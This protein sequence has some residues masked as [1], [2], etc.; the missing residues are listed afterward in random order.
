MAPFFRKT[1]AETAP[2]LNLDDVIIAVLGVLISLVAWGAWETIAASR[3][4]YRK[5]RAGAAD[6]FVAE[7]R[8]AGDL[9]SVALA[10]DLA[11]T[12]GGPGATTSP[13]CAPS[14]TSDRGNAPGPASWSNATLAGGLAAGAGALDWLTVDETVLDAVEHLTHADIDH[15]LDLWTTFSD[16]DYQLATPGFEAMLRG[17]V[18]EQE[19]FAQLYQWAADDLTV[20]EAS[21]HA[22][23]DLT[24]GG[25]EFNV[26]VGADA[27]TIAD[28]L[29]NHP[30]IP[31]IVNDDMQGLPDDALHVDLTAPIDPDILTG[32]SVI[33]A[34][35]LSLSDLQDSMA[36]ALGPALASYDAGDLLDSAGDLAVPL[37]GTAVRV[38]RAGVR[39]QRLTAHHGDT[40]RAVRNVATDVTLVTGGLTAG[41][42]AGVG[43]GALI[44]IASFGA[45]AGLGT[46]VIGPAIGSFLGA[47][48]GGKAAAEQRMRPLNDAR[49]SASSAVTDYDAT[50]SQALTAATTAWNSRVNAAEQEL[51]ATAT[52]L[53][54][55]V[56]ATLAHARDDLASCISDLEA[57][58]TE[59]LAA[60][61]GDQLPALPAV[62]TWWRR[63]QWRTAADEA[64]TAP[65]LTRLDVLCA[66]D[67]GRHTAREL[68]IATSTRRARVLAAAAET[69][70]RTHQVTRTVKA[71]TLAR[72]ADERAR[73]NL[74]VQQQAHPAA[75]AVWESGQRV[76]HELVATGAQ[77]PKWVGENLP[78]IPR[79]ASPARH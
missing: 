2:L 66:T 24:L 54:Q 70:R 49:A 38:V 75:M 55:R 14:H 42:A 64:L 19:V 65:L 34:D 7:L 1:G 48:M 39:E 4:P 47:R 59:A 25:Q 29:R 12:D 30:D 67:P 33:V 10:D 20:P 46:T 16:R 9:P 57:Q 15:G 69:S 35:G 77:T 44:D 21:N 71:H 5:I 51:A 8:A 53:T 26:K 6:V 32:H 40:G 11:S 60:Q 23:S 41:G 63:R 62:V 72:L 76:R 58:T 27:S 31:V 28:H 68:L 13:P 78:P 52:I 37:L 74:Q 36:D 18:G 56:D 45:T 22:A 73:L 50:A 61:L 43:L 79:P 17:H 3:S